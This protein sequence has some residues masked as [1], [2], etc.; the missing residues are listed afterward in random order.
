MHFFKKNAQ[1]NKPSFR[2]IVFKRETASVIRHKTSLATNADA[3]V[4][5]VNTYKRY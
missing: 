1:A 4:N 2:T 3:C 5:G